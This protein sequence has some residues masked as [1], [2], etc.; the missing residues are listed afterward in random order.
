MDAERA[1]KLLRVRWKREPTPQE[2]IGFISG[3]EMG[4]EYYAQT[5]LV[6]IRE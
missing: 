6:Q 5:S 3:W 2:V 4:A 1:T